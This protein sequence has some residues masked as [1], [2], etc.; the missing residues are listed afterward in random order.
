MVSFDFKWAKIK[1]KLKELKDALT[2]LTIE[3]PFC[4]YLIFNNKLV[5]IIKGLKLSGIDVNNAVCRFIYYR[6]KERKN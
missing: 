4:L 5:Y 1:K 3:E 2:V 6:V